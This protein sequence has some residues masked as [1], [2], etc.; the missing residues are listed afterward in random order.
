MRTERRGHY[1]PRAPLHRRIE[2]FI[3]G[4][5]ISGKRL[6]QNPHKHKTSCTIKPPPLHGARQLLPF[7]FLHGR[8]SR[9]PLGTPSNTPNAPRHRTIE[10]ISAYARNRRSQTKRYV[11]MS[12]RLVHLAYLLFF[13][14]LFQS[15]NSEA[16]S[17]TLER[18][19]AAQM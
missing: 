8:Y 17:I 6:F 3:E 13:D 16:I 7:A 18:V 1:L 15:Q 2:E 14:L 4:A 12:K 19:I 11:N 9:P 10:S 5:I